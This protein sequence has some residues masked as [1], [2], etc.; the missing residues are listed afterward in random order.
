M[1][2]V[3]AS[4]VVSEA[5]LERELALV[6]NAASDDRAGVFGPGSMTWQIDKEA[7]IFLGAG[8]AL[9]LQLAHPWI[10][11]AIT[12]HSRALADPIGRF[13]RTFN[14]VFTLVFGTTGQALAAAR[15]LQRRHA[16]ISGTL[17]EKAGPFAAGSAYQANDVAALCWVHATL[18]ESAVVAHEL[19]HPPLSLEDRERYWSEARLFG[20]FFGIPQAALPQSWTD[21]AAGNEAMYQSDILAVSRAAPNIAAQVLSGAG[22]WLRIPFWYRAL[23]A[24]LLPA[25]M[26]EGFG[27]RYGELE[28]RASERTLA[29]LRF[30]YPLV[31]GRLRHVGPYQ[32][33][34]ARLAGRRSGAATQLLNRLW[35]GQKAMAG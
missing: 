8:R 26:R 24:R 23:T 4:G 9:L 16:G 31:P 5:D 22:S 20:S 6:R 19:L 14:P 10:A 17:S 25:R 15:R 2:G 27:L 11:A 1:V 7:A 28:Q 34:C 12:E 21:F 29:V 13:H 3:G 32:E 30:V 33:A 18:V 35:I